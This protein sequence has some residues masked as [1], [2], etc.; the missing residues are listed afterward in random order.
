M[1]TSSIQLLLSKQQASKA[2]GITQRTLA[3]LTDAGEIKCIQ[4]E[5]AC[6]YSVASLEA[7]IAE[8]EKLGAS[9]GRE[10]KEFLDWYITSRADVKPRTTERYSLARRLLLGYFDAAKLLHEFTS[11]DADNW[12][13]WLLTK[14]WGGDRG[15]AD[16]TVRRHCGRVRQFFKVAIKQ[17]KTTLVEENPFAGLPAVVRANRARQYFVTREETL[18]AIAATKDPAWKAIIALSRYAGLRI[19]SEIITLTWPDIDFGA[20]T[21]TIRS[22]KTEHQRDG[23]IRLCPIF[24]ELR[25]YLE[26]CKKDAK[27]DDKAVVPKAIDQT[28]NLR[29]HFLRILKRAGL[30]PWPKLFQNMRSSRETELLNQFP[31]KAVCTWIGNSEAVAMEFYAQVTDEHFR[32]AIAGQSILKKN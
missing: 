32:A 8:K 29:T 25:P 9:T 11:S 3:K 5:R 1:R 2:L 7:W 28:S 6:K 22:T 16:N 15:L 18:A 17:K 14:A 20:G 27:R 13:I 12:R 4:V 10:L 21:M 30:R 19:P 24:P 31:P 23:G 26:A